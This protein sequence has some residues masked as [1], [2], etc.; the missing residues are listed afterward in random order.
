MKDTIFSCYLSRDYYQFIYKPS[1]QLINPTQMFGV[2][3]ILMVM[4]MMRMRI[5]MI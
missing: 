3:T 2:V 5:M 4:M 1:N